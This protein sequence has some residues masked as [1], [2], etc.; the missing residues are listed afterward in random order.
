MGKAKRALK[1]TKTDEACAVRMTIGTFLTRRIAELYPH[2]SK[3]EAQIRVG[4]QANGISL[5]SMQRLCA[6]KV[7]AKSHT[8][9]NLARVLHCS[10]GDIVTPPPTHR[11]A[12]R[13]PQGKS[14]PPTDLN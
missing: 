12:R 8:L 7:D 4:Q 2:L 14:P 1:A 13:R 11:D 5:S 6:G 10:V 3:S 9:A